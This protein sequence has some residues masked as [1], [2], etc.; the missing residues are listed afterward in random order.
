MDELE[1][2][3]LV[4][5]GDGGTTDVARRVARYVR[6]LPAPVVLGLHEVSQLTGLSANGIVNRLNRGI[7]WFP[8]PVARLVCGRVWFLDQIKPLMPQNR[9]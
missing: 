8:E 6:S 1:R 4:A 5:L 2:G 3:I 9:H 7:P